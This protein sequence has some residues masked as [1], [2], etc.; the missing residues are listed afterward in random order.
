MDEV[1]LWLGVDAWSHDLFV[2]DTN[3]CTDHGKDFN[4]TLDLIYFLLISTG[5]VQ[6]N[7]TVVQI[8]H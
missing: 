7:V 5:H 4:V 1:M 8:C 6:K 3:A 2:R